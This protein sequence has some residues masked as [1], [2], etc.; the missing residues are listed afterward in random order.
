MDETRVH[1]DEVIAYAMQKYK[2]I[3]HKKAVMI[4]D[5]SNDIMGGKAEWYG[6]D[7]GALWIWKPGRIRRSRS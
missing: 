1:K 7:R 3:D 2:E 6:Y 5:R 4:G